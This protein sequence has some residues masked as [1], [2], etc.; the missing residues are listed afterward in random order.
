MIIKIV[1]RD[2]CERGNARGDLCPKLDEEDLRIV[3]D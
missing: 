1:K 3:R 2:E